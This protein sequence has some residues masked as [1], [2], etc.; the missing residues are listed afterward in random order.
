MRLLGT[1]FATVEQD[2]PD[3]VA[4]CCA[5]ILAYPLGSRVERPDFGVE[6]QAFHEQGAGLVEI[7]Q[8]LSAWEPRAH[9]T[10]EMSD[11]DLYT[12]SARVR[13]EVGVQR[14]A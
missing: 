6:D 7:R 10:V 9:T 12:L 13:A 11:F 2:T 3:D 1:G 14:T 5:A 4:M 8:A